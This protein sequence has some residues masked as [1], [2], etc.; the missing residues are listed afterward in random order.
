MPSLQQRLGLRPLYLPL[1]RMY[2]LHHQ[3]TQGRRA[4]VRSLRRAACHV[5][6]EWSDGGA[7]TRVMPYRAELADTKPLYSDRV[8]VA[9]AV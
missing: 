6:Q 4:Q 7:P 9:R 3:R 8:R 2:S 1:P 5:P